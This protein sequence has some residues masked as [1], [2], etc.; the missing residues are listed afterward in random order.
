MKG[1]EPRCHR[2]KLYEDYY[3][4]QHGNGLAAFAGSR[5]QRGHGLGN[6]LRSLTKLAMPLL[7]KGVKQMGKQAMKTSMA[8]AGDVVSGENMKKA[9]KR[10]LS[11]GLSALVTQQGRGKRQRRSGPPGERVKSMK[12]I[13]KHGHKRKVSKSKR[14]IS[15]SA[16]QQRTS[17]D[18][19]S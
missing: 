10:R 3:L 8:L 4:N 15:H 2:A 5:Y 16:K 17:K 18:A 9:A 14:I 11:Q 12:K 1:L 7:K 19:L 6:M 13:M